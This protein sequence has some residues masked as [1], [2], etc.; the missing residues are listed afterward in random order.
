MIHDSTDREHCLACPICY[1][2][3]FWHWQAERVAWR[4]AYKQGW[5]DMP[6]HEKFDLGGEA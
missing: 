6:V 1:I 5:R 2:D 4:R 3:D